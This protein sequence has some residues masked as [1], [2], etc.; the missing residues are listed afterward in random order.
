ME[1]PAVLHVDVNIGIQSAVRVKRKSAVA[2]AKDSKGNLSCMHTT[3]SS[4]QN[5]LG[6]YISNVMY[7]FLCFILSAAL[8]TSDDA[9]RF[10]QLPT[11][12]KCATYF[13]EIYILLLVI[14]AA[15]S[16]QCAVY[17]Q[18]FGQC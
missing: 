3:S 13:F 10:L 7:P 6:Q 12:A 15:Y 5:K 8:S 14:Y 18:M 2:A 11:H 4:T 17:F 9:R 16:A 1:T